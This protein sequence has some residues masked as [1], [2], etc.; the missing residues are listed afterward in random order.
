MVKIALFF[1]KSLI[2][3]FFTM[4]DQ[5]ILFTMMV[6]L[7]SAS[8]KMVTRTQHFWHNPIKSV[9]IYYYYSDVRH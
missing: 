4:M 1:I 6:K 9:E 2:I 3:I 7:S 8:L 5:Y